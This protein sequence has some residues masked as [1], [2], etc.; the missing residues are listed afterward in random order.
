M[1]A[2]R[3][4]SKTGGQ[5]EVNRETFIRAGTDRLFKDFVKNAGGTFTVYFGSAESCGD[6]PDRVDAREGWN[7][8]MRIYRPGK[9]VLSGDC[10]LLKQSLLDCRT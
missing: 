9:S 2:C 10:K 6:V 3:E 1:N 4:A 5:D 8:S 7:L